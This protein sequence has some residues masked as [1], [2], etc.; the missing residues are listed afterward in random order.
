MR[1]GV[2]YPIL[3]VGQVAETSNAE[4]QTRGRIY[5]AEAPITVPSGVLVTQPPA[6][7]AVLPSGVLQPTAAD[8]Q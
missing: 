7:V 3:G 5:I 1:K 4:R 8:P 6:P 2:S